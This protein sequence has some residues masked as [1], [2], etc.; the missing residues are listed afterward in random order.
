ME[1]QEI[2]EGLNYFER[3]FADNL[4]DPLTQAPI[5]D[6][7]IVT[8]YP[9]PRI[10]YFGAPT[11][12][13]RA[14]LRKVTKA[15]GVVSSEQLQAA[16]QRIWDPLGKAQ[17]EPDNNLRATHIEAIKAIF[18]ELHPS[19]F[20]D[21][22]LGGVLQ[23][24]AQMVGYEM[25]FQVVYPG[26]DVVLSTR[27][28]QLQNLKDFVGPFLAVALAAFHDQVHWMEDK[29]GAEVWSRLK[30]VIQKSGCTPQEM[31]F[32]LT[33]VCEWHLNKD[34]FDQAD[35]NQ[36]RIWWESDSV[37]GLK[38]EDWQLLL[39]RGKLLLQD[40]KKHFNVFSQQSQAQV[41]ALI[42]A[43]A[44]PVQDAQ[45]LPPVE[46]CKKEK[47]YS[48]E[49][50]KPSDFPLIS[51]KLRKVVYAFDKMQSGSIPLEDVIAQGRKDAEEQRQLELEAAARRQNAAEPQPQQ[52][53]ALPL[54]VEPIEA[55]DKDATQESEKERKSKRKLGNI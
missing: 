36:Q 13:E 14:T 7:V 20:A 40:E 21:E 49:P 17:Q 29:E 33:V 45:P 54:A 23:D 46:E 39:Y 44:N 31:G 32:Y 30:R 34:A 38:F 12:F 18:E 19:A 25:A 35:A 11:V 15:D 55:M 6:P 3:F 27:Y 48:S 43:Q 10:E 26:T 2:I 47:T 8:R 50:V 42:Q 22:K 24:L 51:Q 37:P 53:P 9:Q 52:Q 1:L 41:Q 16:L 28:L 4:V 5:L